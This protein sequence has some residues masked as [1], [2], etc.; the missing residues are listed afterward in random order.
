MI[1]TPFSK[2]PAPRAADWGFSVTIGIG[3]IAE[4]G[5]SIITVT[6]RKVDFGSYGA[7]RAV[8]KVHLL[9]AHHVGE[10]DDFCAL[11]FALLAGD[12]VEYVEPIV[13]RAKE[14]LN[15]SS[16]HPASEIVDA[17]DSAFAESIRKQIENKVLRKRGFTSKSFAETGKQ[18]CPSSAYLTLCER[19]DRVKLNIKFLLGGYDVSNNAH[20]FEIDGENAPKCY[21][22]LGMWAIGS[23]AYTALSCLSYYVNKFGA[24]NRKST[25]EALFFA[26]GAKFMAESSG[27]VGRDTLAEIVT[28]DNVRTVGNKTVDSVREIWDSEASLRV[29]S[30]IENRIRELKKRDNW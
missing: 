22:S 25:E 16:D 6:D 29:P 18:K 12:D 27:T 9:V 20:L 14:L 21:D 15:H 28:F 2:T 5:R 30:D 3:I 4:M 13:I 7:D 23:G 26:L 1:M 17:L 10:H 19:I 24:L 8:D 11:W